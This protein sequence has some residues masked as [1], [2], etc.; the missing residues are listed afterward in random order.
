MKSDVARVHSELVEHVASVLELL[1]VWIRLAQLGY[2]LAV[3][4]LSLII[5]VLSEVYA[6]QGELAD[7]LVDAIAGTLL[8]GELIVLDCLGG[9]ATGEVEVTD[10]IVDLIEIFLVTVI[11]SHAL[12]GIDLALDVVALEH[13]TLLDACV[14]LGAVGR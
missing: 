3:A 11:A 5:L 12:E 8:G 7:C 10:G 9:V 14:E 2:C 1:V 4:W 6:T 13:S